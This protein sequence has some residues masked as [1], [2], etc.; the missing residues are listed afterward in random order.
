MAAESSGRRAVSPPARLVMMLVTAIVMGCGGSSSNAP[1]PAASNAGTTAAISMQVSLSSTEA[2]G[3]EK[4]FGRINLIDITD[5][6]TEWDGTVSNVYY[7]E[8]SDTL[9]IGTP[10]PGRDMA[11]GVRRFEQPL[12]AGVRYTL[13]VRSDTPQAAAI[14]F[15]FDSTGRIIPIDAGSGET[16]AIS[17][18]GTPLAFVAPAGVAGFFLQVQN[19]WRAPSAATLDA[20]LVA[21]PTGAPAGPDLV[22]LG[23]SWPDWSGHPSGVIVE[24][25]IEGLHL[26]L[27]APAAGQASTIGVRRFATPLVARAEYELG[28]FAGSSEGTAVLLFLF[29]ANGR[30]IGFDTGTGSPPRPWLSASPG[31]PSRFV[32]PAGIARFAI[33][34]QSP[35]H[36]TGTTSISPSLV[37]FD[38]RVACVPQQQ[39]FERLVDSQG[40]QYPPGS[41]SVSDDGNVVAFTTITPDAVYGNAGSCTA[42]PAC[43]N[44]HVFVIERN[45]RRITRV[46]PPSVDG[47]SPNMT[48]SGNGRF[49]LFESNATNLIAGETDSNGAVAD[50]FLFDRNDGVIRRVSSGTSA[51]PHRLPGFGNFVTPRLMSADGRLL[52]YSRLRPGLTAEQIAYCRSSA[53]EELLVLDRSLGTISMPLASFGGDLAMNSL[54][55]SGNGRVLAVQDDG[56]TSRGILHLDKIS[57]TVRR[58]LA[59]NVPGFSRPSLSFDGQVLVF[60]GDARNR[61][62]GDTVGG[63]TRWD[64][65]AIDWRQDTRTRLS[66][67]PREDEWNIGSTVSASGNAIAVH[68]AFGDNPSGSS[69]VWIHHRASGARTSVGAENSGQP[70]LSA[71]GRVLVTRDR[72]PTWPSGEYQSGIFVS[73]ID[74]PC[75]RP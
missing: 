44:A 65:F 70:A 67:V 2:T 59:T 24:N 72:V 60:D 73:T 41:L 38:P 20:Q 13:S 55:L 48:L 12:T 42:G 37:Q 46:T 32:A 52:L 61:L 14:L 39:S 27:P 22:D 28:A 53:C 8:S 54:S 64:T 31:Q 29:D 26:V 35:W 30:S 74:Y 5:R 3:A 25:D 40:H 11:I 63:T 7:N 15:L 6:W 36:A 47:T 21:T 57:G 69:S 50:V 75:E 51:L 68:V 9:R 62:P 23:G 45:P 17:R 49:V 56:S 58:I 4:E 18:D 1:A 71:D 33:Q 19:A 10:A 34:V 16:L 43:M 66:S